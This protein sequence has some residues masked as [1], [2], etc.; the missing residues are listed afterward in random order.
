V[1]AGQAGRR[2]Q[3]RVA[4]LHQ[5]SPEDDPEHSRQAHAPPTTA[6]DKL[7]ATNLR[8]FLDDP[9]LLSVVE[10]DRGY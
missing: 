1:G 8:R 4:G 6:I 5:R 9:P 3:A 10:R 2:H 7:F